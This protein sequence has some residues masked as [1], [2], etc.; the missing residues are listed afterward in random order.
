MPAADG[1]IRRYY[2]SSLI[3]DF[4]HKPQALAGTLDDFSKII[5]NIPT[6]VYD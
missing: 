6:M 3:I 1:L 4:F 2:V 5:S